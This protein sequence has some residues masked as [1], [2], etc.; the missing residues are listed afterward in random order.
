MLTRRLVR[1]VLSLG[2]VASVWKEH[3]CARPPLEACA[4]DSNLRRAG[5]DRAQQEPRKERPE[6]CLDQGAGLEG[7]LG[8]C[9]QMDQ[10]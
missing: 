8:G 6:P 4:L 9:R 2:R 7:G 10:R 1:S 3:P 5:P